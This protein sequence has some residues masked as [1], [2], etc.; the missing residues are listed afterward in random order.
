MIRLSDLSKIYNP[1]QNNEVRAVQHIDLAIRSGEGL[2][3]KG[4]SGSGKTTLLALLACLSKPSSGVYYFENEPVS[5]WSEKFLTGF[6]QKNIGVVFQ[7]FQ[8]L[9]GFDVFTN[10]SVPLLPLGLSR[11]EIGQKVRKA[12][13]EAHIEHRLSFPIKNLS[14]GELQRTA[15]ARALVNSP[16]ML[17]ADE[18]TASLDSEMAQK[19]LD[20]FGELK[21]EGKTLILTSHDISVE[22]HALVDRVITMKDGKL[23]A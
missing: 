6:R 14:G 12:A 13:Q 17:L 21:K 5:K 7:N 19:I 23:L 8:L 9:K 11:H 22:Q 4:A 3:I 1:N 16:K 20:L 18:P 10:I 2:L 15:I